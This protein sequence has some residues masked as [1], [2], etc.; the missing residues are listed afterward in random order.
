MLSL[1]DPLATL[2]KLAEEIEDKKP[3]SRLEDLERRLTVL[4]EKLFAALL[5]STP[6]EEIVTFA[7]RPIANSLPTAAKCRRRRSTNCRNNTYTSAS[8]KN[9]ACRA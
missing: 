1:Q 5:A 6:D 4:E 9:I 3:A 7:P 2:R 8:W